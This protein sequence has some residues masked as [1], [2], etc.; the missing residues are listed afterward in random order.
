EVHQREHEVT[1]ALLEG[2]VQQRALGRPKERIAAIS[3]GSDAEASQEVVP[4][5]VEVVRRG[6]GGD[7]GGVDVLHPGCTHDAPVVVELPP[8]GDPGADAILVVLVVLP[9]EVVARQRQAVGAVEEERL[10]EAD[11][12]ALQLRSG[13]RLDP[14][15]LPGSSEGGAVDEVLEA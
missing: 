1:D 14:E 11:D 12:V 3:S 2:D 5:N 15:L 10:A 4:L 7:S 8:D 9:L 13:H 6:P